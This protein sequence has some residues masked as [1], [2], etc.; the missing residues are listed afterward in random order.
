MVGTG[1]VKRILEKH[2]LLLDKPVKDR[3]KFLPY[4]N[5]LLV[6]IA[7]LMASEKCE[8]VK[9][10]E[11]TWAAPKRAVCISE[12]FREVY[13]EVVEWAKGKPKDFKWVYE[14]VVWRGVYGE[15]PV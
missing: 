3:E 7:F 8:S 1:E 11:M 14:R 13:P 15:S 2:G 5:Q 12:V 6:S 4:P 10:W 9:R